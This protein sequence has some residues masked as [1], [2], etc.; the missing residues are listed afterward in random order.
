MVLIGS[1]RNCCP[2]PCLH[3]VLCQPSGPQGT[4]VFCQMSWN[5]K[6]EAKAN[7]NNNDNNNSSSNNFIFVFSAPCTYCNMRTRQDVCQD[8]SAVFRRPAGL[9][10]LFVLINIIYNISYL[11]INMMIFKFSM[12]FFTRWYRTISYYHLFPNVFMVGQ[13]FM[14]VSTG[15]S[16]LLLGLLRTSWLLELRWCLHQVRRRSSS[17][18]GWPNTGHLTNMGDFFR[19]RTGETDFWWFLFQLTK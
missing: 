3:S 4:D 2:S 5:L 12:S 15:L 13:R 10:D 9:F 8:V 6:Y 7:H 11:V 17:V 14:V 19:K 18:L 16:V 1:F